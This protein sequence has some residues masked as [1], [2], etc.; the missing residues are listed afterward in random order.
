MHIETL[1]LLSTTH[2]GRDYLRNNGVYEVIR[3]LHVQ[4]TSEQVDYFPN[5]LPVHIDNVPI[6]F[7]FT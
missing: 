5:G 2:Y 4:E 6:R 1:L 7:R 3:A